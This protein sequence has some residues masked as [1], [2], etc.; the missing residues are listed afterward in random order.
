MPLEIQDPLIRLSEHIK[1]IER[2]WNG[3]SAISWSVLFLTYDVLKHVDDH[4]IM[5]Q[6]SIPQY[7]TANGILNSIL[8]ENKII[9][10]ECRAMEAME[11]KQK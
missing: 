2:K 4:L 11:F 10:P 5:K 1:K 7:R 9:Q 3:L 8:I 6:I